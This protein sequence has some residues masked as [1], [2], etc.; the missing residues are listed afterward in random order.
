MV[1]F[2]SMLPS[3]L[4]RG[5][6]ALFLCSIPCLCQAGLTP[7]LV[8]DIDETS[9]A[10]SSS[11]RQFVGVEHGVAFTAFGGREL[12][13]LAPQDPLEVNVPLGVDRR[14]LLTISGGGLGLPNPREARGPARARSTRIHFSGTAPSSPVVFEADRGTGRG[15]WTVNY[16]TGPVELAKP[17]PLEDGSLLRDFIPERWTSY[18][19]AR[20]RTLGTALWKTDGTAARLWVDAL[21]DPAETRQVLTRSLAAAAMNPNIPEFKTGVLQT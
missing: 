12:W 21:I 2:H 9:Y 15:L 11:P 20:H 16:G 7:R 3:R 19:I 17:L 1:S 10:G 13:I 8:R 4:R 18:F 14:L 6:L 5:A